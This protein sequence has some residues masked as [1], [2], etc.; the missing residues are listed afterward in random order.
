[1]AKLSDMTDRLE[2]QEM[3]Q[4]LSRAKE[5]E[6]E[7]KTIFHFELGDPDFNTP[8]NIINSCYDALNKGFTHYAPSSGLLEL[9]VA[10]ADSTER[11]RRGFRPDLNQ[12]LVTPGANVQIDFAV[13]CTANPGDEIIVPDPGFASYFSIIKARRVEA[14]RVPVYEKNKFRLNP[15]DVEKAITDKTKMIIINSPSNPLGAVMTPEEIKEIYDIAEKKDLWLLSDEMYTRLIYDNVQFSSPSIYDKCKERT[16]IVNGFSKSHAM[17]GWRIGIMT[18]PKEFIEKAGLL[19]ETSLSCTSP[20]IQKAA[21]EALSGSN[22]YCDE[23]IKQ[24]K[25]RRDLIVDGLNSLPAISC[26]KPQGAFYVF[27]NIKET[28][29]NSREFAKLMLEE[30][31]VS[32]SPGTA[33]G[34]YGEGYVR[35]SYAN[36]VQNI[37]NGIERMREVLNKYLDKN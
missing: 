35:L 3:F 1:M 5:L 31:G 21:I 37:E 4:I 32:L 10:A 19:M 2:G 9:K 26:I 36:S 16:I 18:A 20:F 34:K 14:I 23:M 6:K 15:K 7:G 13:S 25:G 27:P 8:K 30:G 17:T 29:M 12:L 11:G 28:G 24:Y 33:F 22:L